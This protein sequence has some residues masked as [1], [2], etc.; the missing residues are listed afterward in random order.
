MDHEPDPVNEE[1]R[2]AG[3]EEDDNFTDVDK[4]FWDN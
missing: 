2:T 4:F 3:E 1:S